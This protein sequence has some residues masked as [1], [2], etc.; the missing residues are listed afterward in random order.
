MTL[1]NESLCFYYFR[2]HLF[3]YIYH[4]P[5]YT[6]A[7]LE[8]HHLCR[9]IEYSGLEG[10]KGGASAIRHY[11]ADEEAGCEIVEEEEKGDEEA[12]GIHFGS[13]LNRHGGPH[14]LFC[15]TNL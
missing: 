9:N 11:F 1:W 7:N 5:L 12:V 15:K 4:G 2:F 8:G 13:Y 6:K 3:I 10:T 14:L